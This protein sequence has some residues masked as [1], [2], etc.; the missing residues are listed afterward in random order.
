MRVQ[1]METPAHSGRCPS[2]SLVTQRAGFLGVQLVAD[3]LAAHHLGVFPFQVV[4]GGQ[5]GLGQLRWHSRH[6]HSPK[7]S[8][9]HLSPVD[10]LKA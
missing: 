2:S 4:G 1:S 9:G 3:E 8:L 6:Q 7:R 10:A 5:I